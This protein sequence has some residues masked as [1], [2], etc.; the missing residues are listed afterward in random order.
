MYSAEL[1]HWKTKVMKTSTILIALL[2][3][4]ILQGCQTDSVE[5][6]DSGEYEMKVGEMFYRDLILDLK[7][8]GT[9]FVPNPLANA[10]NDDPHRGDLPG[11]L[12]PSDIVGWGYGT[13]GDECY[14]ARTNFEFDARTMQSR[15]KIKLEYE[16]PSQAFVFELYGCAHLE[17]T[18]HDSDCIRFPLRLISST[19]PLKGKFI[20]DLYIDDPDVLHCISEDLARVPAHIKGQIYPF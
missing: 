5:P 7:V 6:I 16:N 15:G 10:L 18:Y 9:R 1:I 20:G 19:Y 8:E 11:C 14:Q 3:L 17:G 4:M 13:S 12:G 2:T